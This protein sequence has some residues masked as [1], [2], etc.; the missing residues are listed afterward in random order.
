MDD[1]RLGLTA[2]GEVLAER[3]GATLPSDLQVAGRGE[4]FAVTDRRLTRP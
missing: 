4:I 2:A 1:R 3:W